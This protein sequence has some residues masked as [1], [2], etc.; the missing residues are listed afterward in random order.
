[1]RILCIFIIF[2][3]YEFHIDATQIYKD[4]RRMYII[5]KSEYVIKIRGISQ[6]VDDLKTDEA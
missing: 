6:I 4:Y 2:G 3:A 5:K 1:M